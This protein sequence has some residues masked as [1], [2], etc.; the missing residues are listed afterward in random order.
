[1]PAP[2]AV[3]ASEVRGRVIQR[4]PEK[5]TIP[6][7]R[8]PINHAGQRTPK[9]AGPHGSCGMEERWTAAFR[10]VAPDQNLCIFLTFCTDGLIL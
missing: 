9:Y 8:S 4:L 2:G 10:P 5:A 6:K 1:M 3:E 7:N